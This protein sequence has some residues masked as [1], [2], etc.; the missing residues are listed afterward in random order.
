M[1]NPEVGE[2]YRSVDEFLKA[3][4]V[5]LFERAEAEGK[6]APGTASHSSPTCSP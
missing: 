3:S 2:I 5:Q 1:R 6:I 4:M